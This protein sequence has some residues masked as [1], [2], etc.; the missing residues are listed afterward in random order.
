VEG[1][2]AMLHNGTY[3]LLYSGGGW[4]SK[5]SM[6]YATASRPLG[7]FTKPPGGP[8]L[9]STAAVLGP[10]GGDS[11]V[12]GPHGATWLLYHGRSGDA[13]NPRTLRLDSFSW[14]ANPPSPDVPVISGPTSTGQPT[15]P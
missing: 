12:V 1:P 10:G 5:Y 6:G 9:F 2:T 4:R 7:P 8:I 14:R 3:Y 13:S 15:Q 11:P